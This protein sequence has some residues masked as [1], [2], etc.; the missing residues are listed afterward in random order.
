MRNT[1]KIHDRTTLVLLALAGLAAVALAAGTGTAAFVDAVFEE[2]QLVWGGPQ[3]AGI[4]AVIEFLSQY[5]V[6]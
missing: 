6:F 4:D 5:V 3:D 2:L 1:N